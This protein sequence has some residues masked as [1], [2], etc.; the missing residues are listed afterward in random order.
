[1][2][3]R[4]YFVDRP[5]ESDSAYGAPSSLAR[6]R[7]AGDPAAFAR[8]LAREG[9]THVVISPYHYRMDMENGF[10]YSLIDETYYPAER[11]RADQ[12]LLD[13]FVSE[14]LEGIEWGGPWAVFRL[15]AAGPP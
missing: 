1:W 13:R 15:R 5:F 4:L 14:Q 8:R 6:L 10:L 12:E 3:N 11:L 7:E 2:E 9:F